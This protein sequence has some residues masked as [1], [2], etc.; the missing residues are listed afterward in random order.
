[1]R[2]TVDGER[3]FKRAKELLAN[4]AAFEAD[5]RGAQESRTGCCGSRCR[6]RS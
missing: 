2:L 1:M 4:W 5:L 6:T 3:C